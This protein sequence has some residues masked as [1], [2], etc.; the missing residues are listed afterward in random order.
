MRALILVPFS[1][2]VLERLRQSLEVIYESWL[3]ML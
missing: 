2:S 3:E 1:L